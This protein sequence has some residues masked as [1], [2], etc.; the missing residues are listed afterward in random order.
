VKARLAALEN[1]RKVIDDKDTSKP[2]LRRAS[3]KT[4]KDGKTTDDDRPTLHRR[5]NND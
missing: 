2:S 4:D 3:N 5:D 1:R